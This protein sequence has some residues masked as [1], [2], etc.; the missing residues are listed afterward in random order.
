M[1]RK[2]DFIVL[3]TGRS[4]T[5]AVARYLSA[6]RG[7]HCGLELFSP[8]TDHRRLHPPACFEELTKEE[9]PKGIRH[10]KPQLLRLSLDEIRRRGGDIRYFGNKTPNYFFRL[11][12]LLDEI[13]PGKAI[14]C[15]RD[16]MSVAESYARRADDPEDNW[17]PGKRAIFAAADT[18]ACLQSLLDIKGHDVMIVPNRAMVKDWNSV[19]RQMIAFLLPDFGEVSYDPVNLA[20]I[21][22]LLARAK[23][24]PR[25]LPTWS[26]TELLALETVKKTGIDVLMNRNSVFLLSEVSD[27][28]R[29]IAALLPED[30]VRHTQSLV[31]GD[32]KAQGIECFRMW[33]KMH[34]R[35][36]RNIQRETK[37]ER[38]QA[39]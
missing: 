33:S 14:V 36:I 25:P 21:E 34:V 27:Q 16:L 20:A 15:W 37:P 28:L 11:R 10:P 38:R 19:T 31:E 8:W 29:T 35:G 5:S 32:G 30:I 24:A 12:G 2:L 39:K 26:P 9:L 1:D 18:M 22:R 6:V 7:V 3:G 23:A 17:H 4:G 13:A